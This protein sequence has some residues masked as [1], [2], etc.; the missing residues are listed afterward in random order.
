VKEEDCGTIDGITVEP[1][2]E[3]GEIIQTL[4]QR[5]LGRVALEDIIDP[6][7]KEIIVLTSERIG[8]AYKSHSAKSRP[9]YTSSP[10]FTLRRAP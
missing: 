5:I 2:I 3:S 6:Y 8:E 10:S 9:E 7:T 1:L 4:G